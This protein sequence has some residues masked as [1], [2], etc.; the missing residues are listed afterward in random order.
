MTLYEIEAPDGRRIRQFSK[1]TAAEVQAN[2]LTGYKVRGTVSLADDKGNGG[3]LSPL[4]GKTLMGAL[5]D[6]HGDELM[7]WLKGKL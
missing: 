4:N 3:F 5:L 7:A 1:A 6:A 2:L